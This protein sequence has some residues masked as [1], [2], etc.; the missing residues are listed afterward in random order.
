MFQRFEEHLNPNG[1]LLFTSGTEHG[2]SWAENGGEN[3]FHASLDT[4]EYE[5]LL[6]KHHFQ[7][8]EHTMNDPDCGGATV[9]MAE[10]K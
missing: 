1:I 5:R 2:E 6:Q 8:L 3:L 10:L 4:S 7:V 9:W